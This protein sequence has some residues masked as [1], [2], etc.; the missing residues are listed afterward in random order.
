MVLVC[1]YKRGLF[2]VWVEKTNTLLHAKFILLTGVL[3]SVH[4]TK[5]ILLVGAAAQFTV[6]K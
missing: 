1:T 3:L 4:T 2:K 6:K 5:W